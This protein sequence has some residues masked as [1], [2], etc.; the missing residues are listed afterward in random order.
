MESSVADTLV[1]E[2]SDITGTRYSTLECNPYRNS[3]I[4]L[5][6]SVY[7]R[8]YTEDE[9][10][11]SA[12][13]IHSNDPFLGRISSNAVTPPHT[14]INLKRCL[15][16]VE[17]I[18]TSISTSLFITASAQEPLDDM[19]KV[20]ILKVP[21]PGCTPNE[22]MALVAKVSGADRSTLEVKKT[23]QRPQDPKYFFNGSRLFSRSRSTHK[24]RHDSGA[25]L[26]THYLY[27]RVYNKDS[28]AV[29]L[30]HPAGFDDPS[31]GHINVNSIPPPHS[32][33]SI[34][35]RIKKIEK[36]GC[37]GE[38]QLF[39]NISSEF[40]L[41]EGHLS[42]LTS[43]RPGST[44]K[45]PMAFVASI[46]SKFPQRIRVIYSWKSGSGNPRWLTINVGEILQAHDLIPQHPWVG[47]D[48]SVTLFD[49]YKAVNKAGIEGFVPTTYVKPC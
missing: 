2:G 4:Y 30:H 6:F 13:S 28:G 46:H 47:N 44:P 40:P 31:V 42:I 15:L 11:P 22:P 48:G 10:I 7:Y 12:N 9:S 8:L 36:L 35:R 5:M 26:E 18:D 1:V 17:N 38:P 33:A 14:A 24:S 27:Y 45:D 19:A 20:L 37:S 39:C 16:A 49:A 23:K 34:I 29:L 43:D 21:G 3:L 32:A 25:H 41:G